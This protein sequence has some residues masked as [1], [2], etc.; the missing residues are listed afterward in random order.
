MIDHWADSFR[1]CPDRQTWMSYK[2]GV[3]RSC[4]P[5]D[6][7]DRALSMIASLEATE[8]TAYSDE[9]T[10]GKDGEEEQSPR[11]KFLDWAKKQANRRAIESAAALARGR[12]AMR[13]SVA[14]FDAEPLLLNCRNGVV[15]LRTGELIRHDPQQR[16]TMQC[17]A[18]YA[19]DASAPRWEKFLERVQPDPEMR[20]YLRRVM[21][22]TATAE[23]GEQV[24]WIHHGDGQNGKGVFRE[25]ISH[26]LGQYAQAV[27]V[28][29]LMLKKGEGGIPN[30]V[31]RMVGKRYLAASES[32][33]GKSLDEEIIKRLSGQDTMT[34]RFM[35][36]EFFDFKPVGKIHLSTN[37]PPHVSDDFAIW[38]R[39]H[40]IR[41]GEVIP[42]A[43]RDDSLTGT[44]IREEAPGILAWI[45]RGAIEWHDSRLQVPE[46]AR[47]AKDEYRRDEDT[48]GAFIREC[49]EE[50]PAARGAPERSASSIYA[51]YQGWALRQGIRHPMSQRALTDAIKKHKDSRELSFEYVVSNGW[52]GFPGLAV[53]MGGAS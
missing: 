7:N 33:Q 2:G 5:E 25:V 27:P 30:D 20:A 31:A 14:T 43:E 49:L 21:G 19:P 12:E 53:R 1:W 52:R 3:W 16:M 34:A 18:D 39:I 15:D 46:S 35:R 51:A 40:L 42:K 50:V 9:G 41:W 24:F 13:I 4:P 17:Q 6:A 36:S 38:R 32:K 45:V 11:A 48:V 47:A 29:T 26:V 23:T 44:L 22:Y 10:A 28:E 8:A 37:H